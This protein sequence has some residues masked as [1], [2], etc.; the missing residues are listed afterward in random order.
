MCI[1]SL[2]TFSNR[3]W[4]PHPWKHGGYP[5]PNEVTFYSIIFKTSTQIN[6]W[7]LINDTGRKKND[8]DTI[9]LPWKSQAKWGMH[10]HT[11]TH[12]WRTPVAGDVTGTL[13]GTESVSLSL[14]GLAVYSDL[15]R[16]KYAMYLELISC[17]KVNIQM[18]IPKKENYFLLSCSAL[19]SLPPHS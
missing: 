1:N 10:A 18:P 9:L 6:C 4:P 16:Q 8:W 13:Q 17:G 11:D 19:F 12:T 2:R 5:H 3:C 15:Q 7:A 14:L